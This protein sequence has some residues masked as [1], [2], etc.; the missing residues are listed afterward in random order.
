MRSGST[1]KETI[2]LQHPCLQWPRTWTCSGFSGLKLIQ[3]SSK[4]QLTAVAVMSCKYEAFCWYFG[5][6][7]WP[8]VSQDAPSTL[9]PLYFLQEPFENT[10]EKFLNSSLQDQ[11]EHQPQKCVHV[12]ETKQH[13]GKSK[14]RPLYQPSVSLFC[15]PARLDGALML[16]LTPS[17]FPPTPSNVPRLPPS[18]S[19][20]DPDGTLRPRHIHTR[21]TAQ[22]AF[23]AAR[24]YRFTSYTQTGHSSSPVHHQYHLSPHRT[25]GADRSPEGRATN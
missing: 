12:K 9:Q 5:V 17:V 7:K 19:F 24:S 1:C 6:S 11:L 13:K 22:H 25:H 3:T 14:E 15:S 21:R 16:C 23:S 4:Y 18:S 2:I 10:F 20:K 8:N